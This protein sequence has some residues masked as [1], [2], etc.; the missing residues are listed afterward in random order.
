MLLPHLTRFFVLG[1]LFLC[2]SGC[3]SKVTK[4]NFDKITEGMDL[5]DVEKI[6]GRGTKQGD[7]VGVA[8]QFGVELPVAK[9]TPNTDIYTWEKDNAS[10]TVIFFNGKVK[11]KIE[12]GL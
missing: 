10:I 12:K 7:G 11:T 6:L 3:K 1:C 2:L 5:A 8:N 9:G 4:A